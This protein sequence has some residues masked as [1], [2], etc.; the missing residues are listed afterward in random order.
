M[1]FI[2]LNNIPLLLLSQKQDKEF[3]TQCLLAA[4]LPVDL[5]GLTDG[6]SYWLSDIIIMP[7]KK[8]TSRMKNKGKYSGW[9]YSDVLRD[10]GWPNPK[11]WQALQKSE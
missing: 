2:T 6:Y 11:N 5:S 9:K 4:P 1:D 8:F 7:T 3:G 10:P